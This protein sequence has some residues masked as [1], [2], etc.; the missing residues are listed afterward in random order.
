MNLPKPI[1]CPTR[2]VP[3]YAAVVEAVK[4]AGESV[5]IKPAGVVYNALHVTAHRA[6]M[7]VYTVKL[8]GEV[9]CYEVAPVKRKFAK[10]KK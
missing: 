5:F 7:G 1:A 10:E 8:R 4:R 9:Y 2:I 6:G 3:D